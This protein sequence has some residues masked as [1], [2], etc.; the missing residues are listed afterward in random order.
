M[1]QKYFM[2]ISENA[3]M[4]ASKPSTPM[5]RKKKRLSQTSVVVPNLQTSSPSDRGL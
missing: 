3:C 1:D 2:G 5:N 4:K